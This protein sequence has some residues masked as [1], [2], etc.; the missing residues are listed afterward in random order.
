MKTHIAR[1]AGV[2]AAVLALDYL[3]ARR[4]RPAAHQGARKDA[5]LVESEDDDQHEPGRR[6]HAAMNDVTY[7]LSGLGNTGAI[8]GALIV[9]AIALASP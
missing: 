3:P 1:T 7:L 9:V 2:V 5:A 8:I 6:P 4:H